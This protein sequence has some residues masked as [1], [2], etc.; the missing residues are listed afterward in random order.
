VTLARPAF[1]LLWAMARSQTLD[2]RLSALIEALGAMRT[3]G[4]PGQAIERFCADGEAARFH[5]TRREDGPMIVALLGGTGTGKSTLF[6]RILGVDLT[7]TSFRRTFTAGPV[8]AANGAKSIPSKWLGVEATF[9]EAAKLPARG[10]PDVLMVVTAENDLTRKIVLVD[11]PDLDGD[12]PLH[13]AQA[14]RVFRWV[15]AL[16]FLVTPEKYQ[17]TEL[18]PYYRLAAR[19]EIP[20]LF[21]M[22]KV[23]SA[24]V[25]EDFSAQL[26]KRN[27]VSQNAISGRLFAIARDDSGYVPPAAMDLES[28][29]AALGGVRFPTAEA[30]QRGAFAR[31]GDLLGRL[32]DQVIAPLR[33]D[34]RE[35]GR[36]M[37]SLQAME[38]PT[39]E[40]DV[41]PLMAALQ[42]RLQQRSILYLIGPGRMIDRVRQMPG[43]IARLPRSTLDFMRGGQSN[44]GNGSSSPT[45]EGGAIDLR[46]AL[47][48]QFAIVQSRID[49]VIRANPR[50]MQ[51]ADDPA[52]KYAA[53]KITGD[54]AARI[55][56]EE[57]DALKKWM[58]ERWNATP[59]DTAIIKKLIKHLPGGEKLTALSEAAPYLVIAASAVA[60]HALFGTDILVFG[61]YSLVTWLTERISNEVANRAKMT[62]QRIAER[63]AALA[64][65]QIRRTCQWIE[66]RVPAATALDKIE[67]LADE[68]SRMIEERD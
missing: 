17:M 40:V 11:T 58:N 7:A 16:L 27:D 25:V 9:V 66:G 15:D 35:A 57:L 20:T 2:G 24:A 30:R 26:V 10:E 3:G 38:S 56:D 12:Q 60:T 34:R 5:L 32:R 37:Q 45:A 64:H 29:R 1:T 52:A 67:Q 68:I 18:L 50:G 63:F 31:V 41:N 47:T 49:D 46:A 55:A 19:Y 36:V 8:A 59:R 21:A 53:S 48:D 4:V 14:D 61:G 54:P 22:N 39:A 51:W 13:H 42:R 65:S 44:G 23:E 6:N 43:L 62:N 33:N 28:L